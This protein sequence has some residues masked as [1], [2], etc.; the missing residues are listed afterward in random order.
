MM[1][2]LV[3]LKLGGSLI[4]D[5][6]TA[7]TPNVEVI[8]QLAS[9]LV[10]IR[11]L[12]PDLRILLGHGSGSFGHVPAARYGTR[13]GVQSP[14]QWQGFVE[15]WQEAR[16]L[17]SILMRVLISAGLNAV[18]FSPCSQVTTETRNVVKW[19]LSLI[20][21]ALSHNLI[22]VIHGDTLFDHDLGGTILS[23]EELFSYL[24]TQL[25]P[26]HILIAGIEE[27]IWS[28]YPAR[29]QLITHLTPSSLAVTNLALSGAE[30]LDVTGGMRSKVSEMCD[31]VTEGACENI[32]IFSGKTCGNIRKV[33]AGEKIGTRILKAGK[34]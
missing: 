31:L 33:L 20:R 6:A 28:D 24:A 27:G 11:N 29:K 15:V 18:T 8:R 30:S 3:F 22:P 13:D 4:T 9:E 26:D 32:T 5:K 14:E 2:R 7:H 12:Y 16:A 19:D 1:P 17:N 34:D 10:E 23:T 25:H 21:I